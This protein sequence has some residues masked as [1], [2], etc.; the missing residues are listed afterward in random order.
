M[1]VNKPLN[2]FRSEMDMF[3]PGAADGP[4]DE[5]TFAAKDIIDIEN[6]VTGCG[7]P[8]W[9][10]THEPAT[11][12]APVI[13]A[14]IGA[15]AHLKGKTITDELAFSMAGENIHY[16]T[17]VNV[18]APGRIP[19]GS[20]AGS[21]SAVAGKAVD[22]ALGSDTGGSIR[23]PASHCGVFGIRPSHGRVDASCVMPLAE[24]YDTIGWF[25]RDA[26]LLRRVGQILLNPYG[27]E[28]P[29]SK[30]LI[31]DDA[32]EMADDVAKPPLVDQA[33]KIANLVGNHENVR[34]SDDGL[35]LLVMPFRYIQSRE[36]WLN[37]G[38][39][40]LENKPTLGPGVKE[41]FEFSAEVTEEQAVE[42]RKFRKQYTDHLAKLIGN[43]VV[44][45]PSAPGIAP[46]L[47]SAPETVDSFRSRALALTAPAGLAG[48]PQ[49]SLPLCTVD[50]CPV[51]ISIMGGPG[52][53]ETLLALACKIIDAN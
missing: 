12:M 19:G 18:N 36:A 20:S 47:K 35:P 37:H 42:A 23:V 7:N 27:N 21:A 14:L 11:K 17:P 8:D 40:I 4:L 1:L 39:W 50:E 34:L 13:D 25:T 52:S 26:D 5:I 15:G 41:R 48:L 28:K 16:G 33:N 43:N 24:S 44:V 9:A 38:Q 32:F 10:Q 53:D 6:E 22:F 46:L 2:A 3:L 31:A 30:I 29:V 45:M 49:I 51:G